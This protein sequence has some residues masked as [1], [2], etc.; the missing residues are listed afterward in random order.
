MENKRRRWLI[1]L[2]A[3]ALFC[4]TAWLLLPTR[5]PRYRGQPL[6]HWLYAA[7][8]GL[9][10]VMS[11]P[12]WGPGSSLS[13]SSHMPL[14][15]AENRLTEDS[16]KA[17]E[18]A[19]TDAIPTL[20]RMLRANDSNL[21]LRLLK[22]A[23][24][25]HYIKIKSTPALYLNFRAREGFALLASKASN[26]VPA[27]IKICDEN[28]SSAS[29]LFALG[30]LGWIGPAASNAIPALL[31]GLNSTNALDPGIY[32]WGLK[33]TDADRVTALWSLGMIHQRPDL[34]I[35]ALFKAMQDPDASIHQQA[36]EALK[37]YGPEARAAVEPWMPIAKDLDSL[38]RF[39]VFLAMMDI[40]PDLA[41]QLPDARHTV[42][43][44]VE[45]LSKGTY[46]GVNEQFGPGVVSGLGALHI[47]PEIVV[48]ALTTALQDHSVNI[49][50]EAANALAKFGP[51]ARPAIP[52]LQRAL[53]NTN[54][55]SN[56]IPVSVFAA[57][58]L[59]IID[60]AA[61]TNASISSPGQP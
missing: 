21:K 37:A 60:S 26:A 41:A 29:H 2:V 36:V 14:P 11:G 58:T 44:R 59:K 12:T 50:R 40:S 28:I 56:G 24:K 3:A 27:L 31:R 22:L 61:A 18:A 54:Q 25:Q 17:I 16:K 4:G 15:L 55:D 35:P 38:T 42:E 34:V 47:M 8:D 48:P 46:T 57:R 32:F 6:S 7:D 23:Q 13:L 51:D 19:G 30:S 20:L 43:A 33:P 1:A 53:T 9:G 45:A 49:R 39:Y 5:E 10:F 52:A